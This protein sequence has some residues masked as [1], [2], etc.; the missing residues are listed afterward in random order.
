MLLQNF[1][2]KNVKLPE[3][4]C[5]ISRYGVY[6]KGLGIGLILVELVWNGVPLSLI[7]LQNLVRFL[8]NFGHFQSIILIRG[9]ALHHIIKNPNNWHKRAAFQQSAR[10][11]GGRL[12]AMI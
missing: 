11:S 9:A 3:T 2:G 8:S 1:F 4:L 6:I 10:R 5:T 7:F 12:L